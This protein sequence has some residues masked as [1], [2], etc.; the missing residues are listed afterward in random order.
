MEHMVQVLFR[1]FYSG[2]KDLVWYA[3]T[4]SRYPTYEKKKKQKQ[5]FLAHG[6]DM[7]ETC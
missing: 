5:N 7:D 1:K 2:Y 3:Q 4:G 6:F